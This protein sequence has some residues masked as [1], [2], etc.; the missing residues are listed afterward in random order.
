[1]IQRLTGPLSI[2]LL[3]ALSATRADA[4]AARSGDP[5]ADLDSMNLSIEVGGPLDVHGGTAR[6]LFVGD[7]KRFNRFREDLRNALA[8]KLESCG[9]LVDEGAKDEVSVEVFG[10]L[11]KLQQASP[12]YIY[13]I[14]G[15]VLNSK[16]QPREAEAERVPL[17]PVIGLADEEGVE[18]AL[19]ETA[20]AMIAGELRNCGR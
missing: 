12:R 16:L 6:Q 18:R 20:V 7:L 5:F 11:E 19:I 8:M 2:V 3:V 15:E 10:R 1:M 4:E 9:I 13:M 17:G 14:R